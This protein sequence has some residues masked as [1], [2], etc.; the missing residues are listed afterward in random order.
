M[1]TV[2]LR[3]HVGDD[4]VLR[5]EVPIGLVNADLEIVLVV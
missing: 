1:K 4:G 2:T 5:L 3:S